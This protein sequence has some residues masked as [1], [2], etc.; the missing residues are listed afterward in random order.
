MRYEAVILC[1]GEAWR[2]KPATHI[3]KPLLTISADETLVDRQIRWLLEHG[4]SNIVLA[5]NR[6]FPESAYF[7]SPV[8]QTSLEKKKLG[9]G[10]ALKMAATLIKADQFYAMNVD[11]II[12]YDPRTL[13]D[14]ADKGAAILLVQPRLLFGKITTR[15]NVVTKFED[16]PILDIW[17][18]AGHYVFSKK[19]VEEYFPDEGD[20]ERK[21]MQKIV[22]DKFLKGLKYRGDWLTVNTMKDLIK[23]REYFET[24]RT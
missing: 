20:F 24:K 1:G 8:V 13:Y 6:S 16:R 18:S 15:K 22:S 7:N 4:F 12:F 5:S 11:D 9:T 2:L 3:P 19:L 21:A 14:Y 17:V 23:I 10:G